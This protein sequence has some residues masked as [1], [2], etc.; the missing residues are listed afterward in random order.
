MRNS[1]H[2]NYYLQDGIDMGTIMETDVAVREVR[3]A[4]RSLGRARPALANEIIRSQPAKGRKLR[5]PP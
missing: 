3:S 2:S 5:R 1:P 4:A